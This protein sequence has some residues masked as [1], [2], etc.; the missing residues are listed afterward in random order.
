MPD[1][2]EINKSSQLETEKER[3]IIDLKHFG[4]TLK[5]L[6]RTVALESE[7]T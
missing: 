6:V 4:L 1:N 2:T 3:E 5:N 7:V